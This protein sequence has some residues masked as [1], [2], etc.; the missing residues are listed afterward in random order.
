MI[1]NWFFI[2]SINDFAASGLKSKSIDLILESIGQ[3]TILI[4]FGE[5]YGITYEGVFLP[6]NLNG[7]NPFSIDS[8]AVYVDENNDVFLGIAV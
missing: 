6:V 2:F 4:T 7:K 3:K 8:L 5:S 1:Y